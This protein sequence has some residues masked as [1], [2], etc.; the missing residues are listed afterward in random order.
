MEWKLHIIMQCTFI[1]EGWILKVVE[2]NIIFTVSY[3]IWWHEHEESFLKAQYDCCIIY[4]LW[5]KVLTETRITG[6]GIF[7]STV[8]FARRYG[9]SVNTDTVRSIWQILTTV[10]YKHLSLQYSS[11]DTCI[12]GSQCFKDR[13]TSNLRFSIVWA[14]VKPYIKRV[15]NAVWY[16]SRST[17]DLQ[18]AICW[19]GFFGD[20]A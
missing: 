11:H 4:S 16:S 20:A 17:P 19:N 6:R 1:M 14:E 18:D 5:I 2:L 12:T 10:L 13:K 15:N 9:G 8:L 3:E 7:R